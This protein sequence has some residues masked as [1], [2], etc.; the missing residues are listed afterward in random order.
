MAVGHLRLMAGLFMIPCLVV[1]GGSAMMFGGL[2][3]MLGSFPM[4]FSALL[5]HVIFILSF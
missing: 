5:R 4:M 3:V 2:L 1:L